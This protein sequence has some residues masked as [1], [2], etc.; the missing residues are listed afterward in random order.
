[1]KQNEED[2]YEHEEVIDGEAEETDK[3]IHDSDLK[4]YESRNFRYIK[5]SIQVGDE[6]SIW[7]LFYD[8][9]N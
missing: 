5:G 3:N 2:S 9:E 7:N 8:I 4:T 1:M 6:G